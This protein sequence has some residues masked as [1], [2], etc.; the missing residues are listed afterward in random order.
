MW[1]SEKYR[2]RCHGTVSLRGWTATPLCHSLRVSVRDR[3][4]LQWPRGHLSSAWGRGQLSS[5]WRWRIPPWNQSPPAALVSFVKT[6][7]RWK[8]Y[9]EVVFLFFP[10]PAS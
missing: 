6:T 2:K 5:G 1:S 4:H 7:G 10:A 8:V 3:N 9:P